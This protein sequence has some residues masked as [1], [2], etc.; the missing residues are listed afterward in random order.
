MTTNATNTANAKPSVFISGSIAIR[1][2][3]GPVTERIEAIFDRGLPVLIGDARGADTAVQR[4][5]HE[6]GAKNLTVFAADGFPRNNVGD[7]QV[8]N[9][10]GEGR[11]G[12][13]AF[14]AGKDR[15]MAAEADTGL[16]V[17]DGKSR[18]SL[19]N[20]HRLCGRGCFVAVWLEDEARFE[21]LNS[22]EARTAFVARYP[23]RS[24]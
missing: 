11:S 15:A 19:A 16:V 21:N 1:Q 10:P 2:L 4:L 14:H 3:S 5:L 23:S 18:G 22:D 8:R 12:T 13:A 17:W 7:W 24:H 9:V 20:I 6:R